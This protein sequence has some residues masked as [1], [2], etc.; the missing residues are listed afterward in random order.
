MKRNLRAQPTLGN[1][2]QANQTPTPSTLTVHFIFIII[3]LELHLVTIRYFPGNPL[4]EV[5]PRTK[6]EDR[7]DVLT[8][9]SEDRQKFSS[10]GN[11]TQR[12]KMPSMKC[13][14]KTV[15]VFDWRKSRTIEKQLSEH[16]NAAKMCDTNNGL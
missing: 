15:S 5:H 3:I 13:Y 7:E 11:V 8:I 12:R 9:G 16:K 4:K 1:S 10:A 14:A 2:S 6:G